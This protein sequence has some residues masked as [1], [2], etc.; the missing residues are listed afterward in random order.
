[1]HQQPIFEEWNVQYHWA[2]WVEDQEFCSTLS[3]GV[4][5]QERLCHWTTHLLSSQDWE[6]HCIDYSFDLSRSVR[7]TQKGDTKGYYLRTP[8]ITLQCTM[9]HLLIH[10]IRIAQKGDPK[11]G[12]QGHQESVFSVPRPISKYI[13]YGLH[14]RATQR[15]TQGHQESLFSVPWPKSNTLHTDCCNVTK[16]V[17]SFIQQ[18]QSFCC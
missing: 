12:T 11:G 1:V 15:V 3:Q 16:S 10:C 7:T 18:K 6:I 9:A 5:A 14:K 8:R 17:L 4:T 13:A 2:I